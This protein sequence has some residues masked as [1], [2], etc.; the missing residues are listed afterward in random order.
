MPQQLNKKTVLV[1]PLNWGLGHATRCIPIINCLLEKEVEVLIASDGAAL[2]LLKKEFPSLPAFPLPAYDVRYTYNNMTV[3]MLLQFPKIRRAIKQ[4]YQVIQ[5]LVATQD[6]Q[7][8][9]S[10]NRFGCYAPSTYNVFMTHQLNIMAPFAFAEKAIAW[11]NKKS[12]QRFD[13]C[14][15]PDF[16]EAPGLAGRLSHPSPVERV[17]YIG[18]LSRMKKLT[19]EKKYD[20]VTILSGPEPQRTR[21][22]ELILEQSS[23]LS[24]Q[25]LLVR[26]LLKD[27]SALRQEGNVSIVGHLTSEALEMAIAESAVVIARSGYTTVMDLVALGERGILVP[28]PGQTEQEYLG[29]LYGEVGRFV[30]KTQDGLNL[31]SNLKDALLLKI[32]EKQQRIPSLSKYV[33]KLLQLTK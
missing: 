9:I 18:P 23:K 4:E 26:G 10:D 14:W 22:E 8:I 3:N 21:L 27:K 25:I 1:A 29:E 31:E 33:D 19:V 24:Y 30:V 20:A 2:D 12:L 15:V 13:L 32:N 28:T 16:E 6:I 17:Q 11:W 5:N 7:I